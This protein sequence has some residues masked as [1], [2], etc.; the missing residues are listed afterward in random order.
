[1][2][3]AKLYARVIDTSDQHCAGCCDH[4]CKRSS[5][6]SWAARW[7]GPL[8]LDALTTLGA[9]PAAKAALAKNGGP[10]PD[11]EDPL[12]KLRARRRGA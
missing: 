3:L 11:A 4:D 10:A 8:L 7:I 1:M 12:S 9:T 5:T 2:K 6:A